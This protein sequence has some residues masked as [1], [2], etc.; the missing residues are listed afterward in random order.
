M[1]HEGSQTAPQG[2]AGGLETPVTVFLFSVIFGDGRTR[3]RLSPLAGRAPP[4]MSRRGKAAAS[5][6]QQE[7]PLKRGWQRRDFGSFSVFQVSEPCTCWS[8]LRSASWA[9][10]ATLCLLPAQGRIFQDGFV[11][12]EKNPGWIFLHLSSKTVSS[13]PQPSGLRARWVWAGPSCSHLAQKPPC[14]LTPRPH[15]MRHR[16]S[17]LVGVFGPPHVHTLGSPMG[18]VC[19]DV[20]TTSCASVAGDFGCHWLV[21][22]C[23]AP[24]PG[25]KV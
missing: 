19:R 16:L 4:T 1:G 25:T 7:Q 17:P 12:P 21:P 8:R 9:A 18:Q 2:Q 22:A 6:I 11:T 10:S 15:T 3:T 23:G 20:V 14:S 24:A 5:S 13:G